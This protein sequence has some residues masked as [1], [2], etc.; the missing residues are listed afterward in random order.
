MIRPFFG[1][2]RTEAARG[3]VCCA[4]RPRSTA[5]ANLA[6][7]NSPTA[8]NFLWSGCSMLIW[9]LGTDGA[10]GDSRRPPRTASTLASG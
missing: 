10:D 1:L 8:Y 6:S 4:K 2:Y 3:S 5:A 9:R 7:V